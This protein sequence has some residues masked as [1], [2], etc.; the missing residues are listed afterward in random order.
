M[1]DV[2]TLLPPNRRALLRGMAALGALA[3]LLDP[4]AAFAAVPTDRRLVLVILRGGWDGLNVVVPH[5]DTDYARLR[6]NIA[7]KPPGGDEGAVDLAAGFGLHPALKP[8]K[9]W[10][11]EGHLLAVTAIAGP[12]RTRSHFDAQDTFENGSARARGRSDGWLNRALISLGARDRAGLAVGHSVPLV[13]RG[14]AAVQTWAPAILPLPDAAFLDRVAAMYAADRAFAAA[15]QQGR[16]SALGAE[17]AMGERKTGMGAGP[18]GAGA[19]M[20]ALPSMAEAAGKLLAAAAGPRVATLE[21]EG[22]DT[23]VNE[24][25]AL[26]QALTGLADG[27]VALRKSLGAV[28]GKT[29]VVVASEFGRTAAENGGRGTDHGTGGLLLLAGGAVAGGRVLGRWPG[30]SQSALLEGRDLAPTL[31]LRAVWKAV[32]HDHLRVAQRA[33]EDSIFPDSRAAT[34]LAGLIRA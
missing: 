11:A 21:S 8:L 25:F 19:R 30:L 33:L 12:D 22:W 32:L 20:R 34:P 24:P 13:L 16:R 27:L 14:G 26:Q 3:P 4:R 9:D 31:D 1:S 2:R 5:G 15:L 28:W 18:M 29:V 10:Y 17:Q 23:H 6:P 7:I